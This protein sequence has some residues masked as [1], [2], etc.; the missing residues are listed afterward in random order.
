M[1]DKLARDVVYRMFP[2]LKDGGTLPGA[3]QRA[4]GNAVPA[5]GVGQQQTAP[6]AKDVT[7]LIGGDSVLGLIRA[8]EAR[9][10]TRWRK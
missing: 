8:L 9:Q 4:T 3:G 1:P 10:Q 2:Q 7:Q 6:T 5:S